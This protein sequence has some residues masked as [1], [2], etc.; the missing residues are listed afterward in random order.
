[1]TEFFKILIEKINHA[2]GRGCIVTPLPTR[3][4][5]L[6][7]QLMFSLRGSLNLREQKSVRLKM[8]LL[9][10]FRKKDEESLRSE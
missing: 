3:G 4:I 8:A 9:W 5:K 6:W 10:T 7:D 2:L 1:M